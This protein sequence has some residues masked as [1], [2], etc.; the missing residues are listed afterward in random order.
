V[1]LEPI[2]L[3]HTRDLHA[4]GDGEWL[5]A[6][7][8]PAGWGAAHVPVGRARLYEIGS[9]DHL[10][11]ITF[12]NGV[13]ASLRVAAELAEEGYG[14]RVVDLRWLSPLPVA[15][16]VRESAA[17]GRVLVVDET[18]RSGGVAEGVLAALVDNG[19]VGVA[20]RL[21]CPTRTS[22]PARSCWPGCDY[23]GC[24]GDTRS[25]APRVWHHGFV[26]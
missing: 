25:V 26:R 6:Y 10:T 11:I 1:F 22:R 23:S 9:A 14:T 16:I 7:S 13:R 2:A 8:P 3:Y 21:F 24:S 4:E 5:S 17:T 19:Y 12:G 15:D 20:K 18:R